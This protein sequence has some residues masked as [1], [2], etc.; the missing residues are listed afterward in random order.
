MG[1]VTVIR[2]PLA[3][4]RLTELR[5]RETGTAR[6]RRLLHE[7]GRFLIAEALADLPLAE[8]AIETPF[9]PMRAPRLASPPVAAI[10][11]LRA[12][13]GFLPAL[14]ELVPEAPI[15][16][17]G[18]HR[19]PATLRPVSYYT[20]LP[21]GLAEHLVVIVDPMVATGGTAV[22]AVRR[23]K[24]AGGTRIRFVSLIAAPEGLAALT[25]AHPDVRVFTAAVDE[26]LDAK[27][28]IVPGIGDAGDRLFGTP[29]ENG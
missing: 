15:G 19:D 27:G 2:H 28:H 9:A 21:A 16:H 17:L 24:D 23:V 20:S 10:S 11:I 18:L 12:G 29:P 3:V 6:F 26:G 5:R 8:A 7:V 22:E 25:T 13:E 1:S 14:L 4:D